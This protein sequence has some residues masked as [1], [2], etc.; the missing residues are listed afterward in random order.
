ML[1]SKDNMENYYNYVSHF[2]NTLSHKKTFEGS[3]IKK[4]KHFIWCC[5]EENISSAREESDE[6]AEKQQ[7]YL[8]IITNIVL[9]EVKSSRPKYNS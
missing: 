2:R 3:I 1:S 8:I 4:L 6:E 5:I 7:Y 9:F